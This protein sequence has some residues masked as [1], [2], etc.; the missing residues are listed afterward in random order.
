MIAWNVPIVPLKRIPF[1]FSK[2]S[3]V[4][5]RPL[6]LQ[7]ILA[8][9]PGRESRKPLPEKIGSGLEIDAQQNCIRLLKKRECDLL[10][11]GLPI[12]K[13]ALGTGNTPYFLLGYGSRIVCHDQTDDF[14]FRDPDFRVLDKLFPAM[15]FVVT[16]S[17][18]AQQA[19]PCQASK[20]YLK[21]PETALQTPEK[22]ALPVP[23]ETILLL[24]LDGRLPN[25]ALMKLSRHFKEQGKKVCLVR[26]EAFIR[27]VES[28]Y[29]GCLFFNPSSQE[30]IEKLRTFYGDAL[31]TGG[32]GFDLRL[33]LPKK[34]RRS[35]RITHS[36]RS[37]RAGPLV[38]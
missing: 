11:A 20:N 17:L 35:W 1:D 8:P 7:F 19:F 2:L 9:H 16:L 3:A 14:E 23:R 30:R 6:N 25:L 13:P 38:F 24:Q 26:G 29:A 22:R 15:Q 12:R 4:S 28:A 5:G 34:P 27:G 21:L 10:P 32:S 33:R 36:I 18:R 31:T 37:W